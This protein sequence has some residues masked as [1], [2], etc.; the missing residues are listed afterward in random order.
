[1]K[2]PSKYKLNLPCMLMPKGGDDC[3]L[4]RDTEYRVGGVVVENKKRYR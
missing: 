3:E 4:R 2:T 1:M